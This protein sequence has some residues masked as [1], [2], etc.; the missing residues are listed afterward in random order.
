MH[1]CTLTRTCTPIHSRAHA[2]LYTHTHTDAASKPLTIDTSDERTA[3]F[4]IASRS[5]VTVDVV[6]RAVIDTGGDLDAVM[7]MVSQAYDTVCVCA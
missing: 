7:S 2:P 5:G 3:L 4:T 6:A 1:P